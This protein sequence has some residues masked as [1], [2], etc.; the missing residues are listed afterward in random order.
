MFRVS[1]LKRRFLW[2][3][4]CA[5][6]FLLFLVVSGCVISPRRLP[7]DIVP[8][9]TPTPTPGPSATPTPTPGA[10]PQGKLYVSNSGINAI[11]RFD[12]ALTA[13]G[14]APLAVTISGTNT[15]LNAPEY[16]FLDTAADRLYVANNGDLSILIFDN[17]S[18]KTGNVAPERVIAG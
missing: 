17:I 3:W 1:G 7:G 5:S 16:I 18:T 8:G 9:A 13:S 4:L 12:Q 2:G 11:L 6:S 15:K 10:T 14:N